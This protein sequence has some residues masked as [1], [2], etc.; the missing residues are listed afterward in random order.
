MKQKN[1]L[2]IIDKFGSITVDSWCVSIINYIAFGFITASGTFYCFFNVTET[3]F[4]ATGP[5][6]L[7]MALSLLYH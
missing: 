5:F 4:N 2:C 3:I 6:G 7:F 1:T